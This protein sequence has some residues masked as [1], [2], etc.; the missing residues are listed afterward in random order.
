M[1]KKYVVLLM[2]L[3][4]GPAVAQLRDS[5][6]KRLEIKEQQLEQLYADYWRTEYKAAL[7]D[8]QASSTT[9]H[10]RIRS[11]FNDEQFLADLG[12]AS[13]SDPLLKRRRELF[14]DEAVFTKISSEAKLA[15]LE[16]KITRQEGDF[17]Y[18]VDGKSLSRA[19]LSDLVANSSNRQ[20]R[21]QAWKARAQI[22]SLNG[23]LIKQTIKLRN[24]LALRYSD[25]TFSIFM[26][27]RKGADTQQLFAWFDQFRRET[28]QEYRALLAMMREE[29]RVDRIEPWDLEYYFSTLT[30]D[31]EERKFVPDEGWSKTRQLLSRL[32]YDLDK[33]PIEMRTADLGFAGGAYP[34]L[35]GKEVKILANRYSGIRFDDR[36]L[37]ATG[38][39]LHYSMIDEPSFL[40]RANF[41]EGF[42][43]G[44]AELVTLMLYRPEI[45]INVFGL[46]KEQASLLAKRHRLKSLFDLRETMADSLFEFEAYADADQDL[47]GLYNRIH[48][49]YLGVEMHDNRV[50]AYNPMYGSDPIYLQSFVLAQMVACQIQSALDQRFGERWNAP[51]GQ[52]LR[53]KFYSRGAEQSLDEIM[54]AGT[55]HALDPRYLIEYLSG[56]GGNEK[57]GPAQKIPAE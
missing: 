36:L 1:R 21:E 35:Y 13:F 27:H 11:V 19:Q 57:S 29:L 24:D 3:S 33:L 38:H 43:E 52:Y 31:F 54:S 56:A 28:E 53:A 30:N 7:G 39:A 25:T 22:A 44:V 15:E 26:L 40:L 32:G 16:E 48:S 2:I 20:E 8:K 37:H 47:A 10:E 12:A 23:D 17:R 9:S 6:A 51:V 5:P 18:K 49:Q 45:S 14:L 34:I 46:S 42:D 41:A 50:W 4:S 55:G